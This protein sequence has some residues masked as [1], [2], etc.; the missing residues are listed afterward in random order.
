MTYAYADSTV[1]VGPL[2]PMAQPH[3]YDLCEEHVNRLVAPQG[4]DVVRI[5]NNFQPAPPSDD[6]LTALAD[7]VRQAARQVRNK[8]RE[9]GNLTANFHR[10]IR[11]V[12][13]E[14]SSVLRD[15]LGDGENAVFGPLTPAFRRKHLQIFEGGESEESSN[16]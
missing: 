6:D 13:A 8:N 15:E 16:N 9:V 11:Y 12:E 10:R 2:S 14:E 3:S 4:W 1:V 7:A 5:V